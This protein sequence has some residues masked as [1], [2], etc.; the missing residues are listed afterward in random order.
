MKVTPSPLKLVDLSVI[1]L[2]CHFIA[3]KKQIDVN[4]L[5]E[6]YEVD[7]NFGVAKQSN[8]NSFQLFMKAEINYDQSLALQKEGYA[9]FIECAGIF[10]IE[11][12]IIKDS[13]KSV[14]LTNSALV[15]MLN[16][17]RTKLADYTAQFPFG[18]YFIPSIDL[19]E[20]VKEKQKT[21]T[22]KKGSK[23]K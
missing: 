1:N 18:V 13:E 22:P 19:N 17:L 5:F 2:V 16:F 3:P 15:M 7:I 6:S 20:L 23:K 8:A 11:K 21:L 4:K 10:T 12:D 9:M 14:Q